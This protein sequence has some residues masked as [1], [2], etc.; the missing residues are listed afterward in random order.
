MKRYILFIYCVLLFH[1]VGFSQQNSTSYP[2]I[3]NGNFPN[4]NH[5]YYFAGGI[6]SPGNSSQNCVINS[7]SNIDF[8]AGESVTLEPGF[9]AGHFNGSGSFTAK[10]DNSNQAVLISPNPSSS[11]VDGIVHVNKWEKLEIGFTIPTE[12][13]IGIDN[14][15]NHYYSGI[16][17]TSVCDYDL[18]PYADDTVVFTA[19]FT[20]PNGDQIMKFGF[21]MRS[22]EWSSNDDDASLMDDNTAPLSKYNFRVRYSP[23][24]DDANI[25]WN[26]SFRFSTP[27]SGNAYPNYV[28]DGFKFICDPALSDNKGF[29][30]V[31]TN[32]KQYLAFGPNDAF[33]GM[34]E[35]IS[36]QAHEFWRNS[37]PGNEACHYWAYRYKLDWD[38]DLKT[39]DEI[40]EYHG[41]FARAWIYKEQ[42]AFEWYNLGVYDQ[43]EGQRM[44]CDEIHNSSWHFFNQSCSVQCDNNSN[45]LGLPCRCGTPKHCG[46]GQWLAWTLD[47]LFDKAREK[48]IYLQLN[49]MPNAPSQ[50]FQ[51]SD[52]GDNGYVHALNVSPD[53]TITN[54]ENWHDNT[55]EYFNR[56]DYR[57]YFKRRLKYIMARWGYSTNL[58][59]VELWNEIDAI[60]HFDDVVTG[61]G[62]CPENTNKLYSYDP[63]LRTGIED[64]YNDLVD[65]AKGSVNIN[66]PQLGNLGEDTRLFCI[67]YAGIGGATSGSNTIANHMN[68]CASSNI[69]IIDVHDYND[70]KYCSKERADIVS[71]IKNVPHFDKPIHSGE[72]G[73]FGTTYFQ[74]TPQQFGG[75]D[76][77][78]LYDNYD[79][80]F[81]NNLWATTFTGN[82]TS[83]IDFFPSLNHRYKYAGRYQ[84]TNFDDTSNPPSGLYPISKGDLIDVTVDNTGLNLPSNIQVEIKTCYHNYL[85]L[86]NFLDQVDREIFLNTLSTGSYY[87]EVNTQIE[88]YYLISPGQ[89]T[90][91][92]WI[93]NIN[94]Y[95]QNNYIWKKVSLSNPSSQPLHYT[96]AFTSPFTFN[97]PPGSVLSPITIQP[98]NF[99]GCYKATNQPSDHVTL[100]GFLP[101]EDYSVSFYPTRMASYN[102]PAPHDFT[103]DNNGGLTID[104][105]FDPAIRLDCDSLH[106]DYGF[107]ASLKPH[108]AAKKI[109]KNND[110]L[111]IETF[112]N[113][114]SSIAKF[115]IS[116]YYSLKNVV[117]PN[118]QIVIF[119]SLGE[120]INTYD[121]KLAP[122]IDLD[123]S[124][125]AMG[126]YTIKFSHDDSNI[127]LR[128]VKQ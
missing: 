97:P 11:I 31:N 17:K 38:N 102:F 123:F 119:N 78:G 121:R 96:E 27:N 94:A 124:S 63:A 74:G 90:I 89:T 4:S 49:C 2:Y 12:Y 53:P 109:I 103:A 122:F 70:K 52:W 86:A 58:A 29:L 91:F 7:N 44:P 23:D 33:F 25:P 95:W 126:I 101:N 107:I 57:L 43:Y 47:Q 34:G 115:K 41:N 84:T 93:H 59:I 77:K 82:F 6:L 105:S 36:T 118:V 111:Q 110:A 60:L 106:S 125:Y 16:S 19:L 5:T 99:Y 18:N 79:I 9:E 69:D 104:F 67:N 83:N 15:F 22:A 64:T 113:P 117:N 65:Y 42:Y 35:Q 13:Q 45:N 81:H 75:P 120:I 56:T 48:G 14:F 66:S 3:I 112:P 50:A 20:K 61:G 128:L 76:S 71:L 116:N 87:D 88:S 127:F 85:P 40:S 62:M 28:L 32:N 98:E 10:I 8:I 55:I 30:H 73:G 21:F 39:L 26:V 114:T 108:R 51:V 37:L 46:N 68:L 1:G 72:S 100:T 80:T 92:G 54:G 24:L